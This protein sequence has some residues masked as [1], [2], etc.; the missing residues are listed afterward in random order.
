MR[1]LLKMA[2]VAV[3]LLLIAGC[4]KPAPTNA[5]NEMVNT[6]TVS[7]IAGNDAAMNVTADK[8]T[9]AMDTRTGTGDTR[10]GTGDTRTGTGDTR[11]GTGDTRA[12]MSDTRTGTGDTRTVSD[13]K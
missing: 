1:N 7:T 11:T 13:P 3:P 5:E 8:T 4:N 12:G 6:T 10:T 2:M 9:N